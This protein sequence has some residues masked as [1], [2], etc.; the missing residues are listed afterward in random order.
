[1]PPKAT[2]PVSVRRHTDLSLKDVDLL[3]EA[4]LARER[5]EFDAAA[6]LYEKV[7]LTSANSL[8]A[9]AG[10]GIA[11]HRMARPAQ[12]IPYLVRAASPECDDP[13]VFVSL[14]QCYVSLGNFEAAISAFEQAV[15]LDPGSARTRLYLGYALTARN[16]ILTAEASLQRAI[17]LEPKL[18][19]A[20]DLLAFVLP[21][22]GRFEE[23]R[24][25]ARTALDLEPSNIAY[26]F[27][28]V[29]AGRVEDSDRVIVD[30]FAHLES[31][32]SLTEKDRI[33]LEFAAGKA[34]E[35]LGEYRDSA[36]HYVAANGLALNE[37][38]RTGKRFD[39]AEH[40]REVDYIV[41]G[42]RGAECFRPSS[43]GSSSELP[44]FIV[45]MMRS[46]TTL[47]EQILSAHPDVGGAGE[48]SFWLEAGPLAHQ[49]V[50]RNAGNGEPQR[51]AEQYLR[52]LE[53]RCPGMAR[54]CDKLPQNYMNL[55]SIH[56]I[57]PE[58]RIIHCRR[59]P[60]DVCI[61]LFTTPFGIPPPFAYSAD[62]IASAYREYQ[63]LVRHWRTVLPTDRFLEVDYEELVTRREDT[64][65]NMIAFMGLEWNDACLFPERN[66][67]LV[68]TPSQWQVRQPVYGSSIGRWKR[69][70][71]WMRPQIEAWSSL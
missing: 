28:F 57:L 29:Y 35:D 60:R 59:D 13:T 46:G 31:R 16:E 5:G 52:L 70:A 34:M 12:A 23:A 71:E 7:L 37:M 11:L 4:G 64:T 50:T 32:E 2:L 47:V 48:V 56:S 54:V 66:S 25:H 9:C 6:E 30:H 33:R 3:C 43:R 42:F 18:A 53:S 41:E 65:R 40:G 21:K 45:G 10:L 63:K 19:P 39:A 14:G 51:I 15:K 36:F 61:S 58:A 68:E 69:F 1:V 49:A 20:H 67:R 26:G 22:L 8:P 17:E 55:G 27:R 24:A 38:A 62:H 44:T